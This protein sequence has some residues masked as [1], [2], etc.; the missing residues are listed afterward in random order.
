M[1]RKEE[2]SRGANKDIDKAYIDKKN[3]EEVEAWLKKQMEKEEEN[4]AIRTRVAELEKENQE[5]KEKL[6]K[7]KNISDIK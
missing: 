4:K 2:K 7:L 3:K 6:A 1:S 5:L